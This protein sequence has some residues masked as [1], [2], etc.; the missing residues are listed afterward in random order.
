M[1]FAVDHLVEALGDI[2]ADVHEEIGHHDRWSWERPFVE[3]ARLTKRDGPTAR[4]GQQQLRV[5]TDA[6]DAVSDAGRVLIISHGRVIEAGLVAAVP[7]GDFAAWG[8]P[9][10]HG[11]GVRL[12]YASG[13]FS[14][15]QFLRVEM[16]GD[17]RRLIAHREGI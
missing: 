3:F 6:L 4:M 12:A 10:Q 7:E 5:W 11:E 16:P 13:H 1:G 17:E 9:F 15:V 2:P 8:P 14:V